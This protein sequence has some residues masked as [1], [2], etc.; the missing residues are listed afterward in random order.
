MFKHL[1]VDQTR[2]I[3]I[4]AKA[5]RAQRDA[6]IG[7]IDERALGEFVPARGEH[8]PTAALGFEP[9][10]PDDP[11]VDALRKAVAS[12]S[13]PARRELYALVRIGQGHLAANKWYRGISEAEAL[14]DETATA[15]ILDD[16][17]LHEHIA[18]GLYEAER[19]A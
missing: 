4:L 7:N 3:A 5:A 17:D 13:E 10:P 2:F 9:L 14:G 8:D 15:A 6:L 11:Q 18:K 19:S 1:S 16:A 12:L